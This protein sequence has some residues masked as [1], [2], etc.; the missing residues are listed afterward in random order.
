[1]SPA[2]S[3]RTRAPRRRRADAVLVMLLLAACAGNHE[4]PRPSPTAGAG[5]AAAAGGSA[6]TAG[7]QGGAAAAPDASTG[8]AGAGGAGRGALPAPDVDLILEAGCATTPMESQLLPSNLLF[9][10][11]RSESMA[12]NPPPTTPSE[13]CELEPVRANPDLP[14]KWEIMRDALM[15]AIED[16][17]HETLVGLSYF[18]NDDSCGVHAVPSV[19]LAPLNGPQRSTIRAS[20]SNVEPS[21][22]PPLVGAVVVAYR[23]L[24]EQ[25]L[26]REIRGNK[27]VVLL[28]DGEQSEI[29]SDPARC[30]GTSACTD[31]LTQVEAPKAAAA[32]VSIKTFVIGAPGSELARTVLSRLALAG[33]TARPECDPDLGDCHF[34]MT[35]QASFDTALS[36]A[37]RAIAGRAVLSCELSMPRPDSGEVDPTRVNVIYSPA[38]GSEPKVVPQDQRL[39]C[40]EG[41]NGWQYADAQT[42]IRLCGPACEIVRGDRGARLDVVLGC[43]VRGPE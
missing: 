26:A 19:G 40:D 32:G 31:L 18:S 12:C 11:D 15:K 6:G 2:T 28:T 42:K 30:E 17:P 14:S 27:F 5:G 21:G 34:D 24:H 36:A 43:P 35:T 3:S 39:G 8:R 10:I 7:D 16:L 1:M 23:H 22:A 38:D 13:A 9:V 41:A 4:Q 37:L 29:C 33:G 20:L 25:A